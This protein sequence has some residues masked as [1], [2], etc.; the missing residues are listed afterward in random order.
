GA[1]RPVIQLSE[2]CGYSDD[3]RAGAEV[4]VGDAPDKELRPQVAQRNQGNSPDYGPF[5][6]HETGRAWPPDRSAASAAGFD[7]GG[8]SGRRSVRVAQGST[9]RTGTG[10]CAR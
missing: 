6:R 2:E 1:F 7:S 5:A 10:R 8:D 9:E 3:R 4:G